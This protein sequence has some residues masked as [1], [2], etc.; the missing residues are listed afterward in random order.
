M[1]GKCECRTRH[2]QFLFIGVE[3]PEFVDKIM[4]AFKKFYER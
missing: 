1:D 2:S 4:G 3:D